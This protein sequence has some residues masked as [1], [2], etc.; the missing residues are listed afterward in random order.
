VNGFNPYAAGQKRYGGGAS[1]AANVGPVNPA[2]YAERDAK[3]NARRQAVL[4]RI[5]AGQQGRVIGQPPM[6]NVMAGRMIP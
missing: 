3:L 2:G 4:A 6:Q 5:Q 1:S